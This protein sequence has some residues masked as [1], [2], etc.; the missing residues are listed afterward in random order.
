MYAIDYTNTHAY[1]MY[2]MNVGKLKALLVYG[3]YI[4]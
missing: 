3:D 2:I 4:I 1:Y